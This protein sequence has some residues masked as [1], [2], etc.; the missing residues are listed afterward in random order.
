MIQLPYVYKNQI[1]HTTHNKIGSLN[2]YTMNYKNR[3]N[4]G[5][6]NGG[7]ATSINSNYH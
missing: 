1:L 3:T 4:A 2:N 5:K 6:A 7:V